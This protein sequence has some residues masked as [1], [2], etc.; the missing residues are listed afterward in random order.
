MTAAKIR[1]PPKE[2]KDE[3][4]ETLR[5]KAER[6][7]FVLRAVLVTAMRQSLLAVDQSAQLNEMIAA[8]AMIVEVGF[9]A[10]V[11]ETTSRACLPF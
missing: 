3:D 5:R 8:I 11:E 10:R 4:P 2:V 6:A 9:P 7:V 1:R